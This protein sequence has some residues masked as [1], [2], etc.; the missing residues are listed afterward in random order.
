[1]L[2]KAKSGDLKEI[3]TLYKNAVVS[4]PAWSVKNTKIS[5]GTEYNLSK[6]FSDVY[7]DK[8]DYF[9]LDPFF[10]MVCK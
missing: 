1:M 9:E 6:W 2:E 3:R 7:I 4:V 5:S 10:G 8:G